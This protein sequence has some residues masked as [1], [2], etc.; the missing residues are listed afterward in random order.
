VLGLVA[1]AACVFSSWA[2]ASQS[3]TS[4]AT[5]VTLAVDAKG[6]ALVTYSSDGKLTHLLAWGAVNAVPP[7]PGGRQVAFT[8]D[9]SGGFHEYH[10]EYWKTFKDVCTAYD[11]PPLVDLVAACTAP[12]GSY[13]ALQAWPRNLPDY[14]VS[15]VGTQG[16]QELHLS[17][18]TGALPVLTATPDH[19]SGKYDELFGRFTLDGQGIYGFKVTSTG[20]PL[21]S[22]GRNLY[23]DTFDS[24][25]GNGW[26]RE[27]SLVTH[28][29]GGTFCYAFVAHGKHPSGDGSEYRITVMGP[30][31]EP[32][33]GWSGNA[34]GPLSAAAH[35]EIR[36]ELAALHD[37]KCA[38]G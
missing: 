5:G 14:G 25:Y 28:G 22:F 4:G 36:K 8:L 13:W 7:T 24:A 31:V 32:D 23:I 26:R 20:V 16:E 34:T 33:V 17:H 29:P 11:G 2:A 1:A 30:G 12:D 27:N 3:L 9:Y 19:L 35:A 6:E 21:D 38:A 37:P 18:W 15:P 10:S